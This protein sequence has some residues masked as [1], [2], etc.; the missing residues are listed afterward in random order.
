MWVSKMSFKAN[1][2]IV[3]R[4]SDVKCANDFKSVHFENQGTANGWSEME[5]EKKC[6]WELLPCLSVDSLAFT[7]TT[8]RVNKSCR[9]KAV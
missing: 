6:R 3:G 7:L 9:V 8:Q 5:E 1:K 2:L 4:K